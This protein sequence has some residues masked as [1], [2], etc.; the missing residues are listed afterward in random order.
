MSLA[1]VF[2]IIIPTYNR[3]HLIGKAIE[4]ILCQDFPDF[5]IL[6]VDDGSEDNTKEVVEN[7]KDDR[8]YYYKKQNAER[9]AARNYGAARAKGFYVNFFDSDDL[10]YPNHLSVANKLIATEKK[11]EFFHLAYDYQLIDGRVVDKVNN[12]EESI[13]KAILFENRLSCNG[14]F[15]R[16]EIADQFPFEENRALASSEDWEL[17]IRLVSRFRLYY[18]HEITSSVVSHDQRSLRTIAAENVVVRDLL[19]IEKL[20]QDPEVMHNY[21]R[22]FNRFVADRYTFFM[23]C[24]TEQRKKAD[25]FKWGKQAFRVYPLIIITKRFLASLKNSILQ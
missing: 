1:P 16:K 8:I 12:F 25:V 24:F 21:G 6:V 3:A 20:R 17:W 14:V 15:L 13:Q 7:F 4:S 22:S 2:S 19:L 9:G 23:L 10:M 11:P 18:S 5:E